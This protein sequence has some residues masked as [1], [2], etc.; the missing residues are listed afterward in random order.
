MAMATQVPQMFATRNDLAV[1][2]TSTRRLHTA[3]EHISR[4][5]I[6]TNELGITDRRSRMPLCDPLSAEFRRP[7]NLQFG[8]RGPFQFPLSA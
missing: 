7:T 6:C 1:A 4:G 8:A 5:T 3:L 2:A